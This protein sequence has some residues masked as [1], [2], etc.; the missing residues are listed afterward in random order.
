MGTLESDLCTTL[1]AQLTSCLATSAASSLVIYMVVLPMI[2]MHILYLASLDG[3]GGMLPN[4]SIL[5]NCRWQ[6]SSAAV[7]T[8]PV[9]DRLMMLC[10]SYGHI[11]LTD[12]AD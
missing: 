8:A 10:I 2:L 9:H 5:D 12:E 4:L 11:G 6:T 3:E 7:K 1:V